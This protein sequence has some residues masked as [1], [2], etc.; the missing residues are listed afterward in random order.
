MTLCTRWTVCVSS[1]RLWHHATLLSAHAAAAQPSL[2]PAVSRL[3]LFHA[4]ASA[5]T[6]S[7]SSAA[8]DEMEEDDSGA[9]SSSSLNGGLASL[10]RQNLKPSELVAELDKHIV[11]QKEAK[12]A[13]AVALRNRYRRHQLP[14]SMRADVTPRNILML[15]PTGCGTQDAQPSPGCSSR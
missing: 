6:S 13:V 14:A 2:R 8:V 4:S 12:R 10:P 5:H 1:R 11:G 3:C 9:S 15:G 7:P